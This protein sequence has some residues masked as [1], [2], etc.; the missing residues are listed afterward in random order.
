VNQLPKGAAKAAVSED[1][2]IE[3]FEFG[4]A[5]DF[6]IGVQWH[7]EMMFDSEQQKKLFRALIKAAEKI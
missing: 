3:A 5:N 4:G 6:F 1:G 7:P 2:L